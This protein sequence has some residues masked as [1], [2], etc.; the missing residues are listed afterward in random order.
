MEIFKRGQWIKWK[1]V[2]GVIRKARIEVVNEFEQHYCVYVKYGN[3]SVYQE[4]VPFSEAAPLDKSD[5]M[6]D[7]EDIQS[8]VNDLELK[9]SNERELWLRDEIADYILKNFI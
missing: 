2:D 5:I 3:D 7:L 4:H 9:G 1:E 6:D 8:K